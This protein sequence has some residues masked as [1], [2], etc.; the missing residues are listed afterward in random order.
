VFFLLFWGFGGGG[1]WGWGGR[2]L[3]CFAIPG[4]GYLKK[5]SE[6]GCLEI[7]LLGEDPIK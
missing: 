7:D 3:V 5:C 6:E 2:C 1:G 4:G